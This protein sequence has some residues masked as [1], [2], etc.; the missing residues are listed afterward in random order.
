MSSSH[1]RPLLRTLPAIAVGFAAAGCAIAQQPSPYSLPQR[2]PP[3]LAQAGQSSTSNQQSGQSSAQQSASADGTLPPNARPGE[4]YTRV[5]MAPQYKNVTEQVVKREAGERVVV[6]PARYE[7]APETVVVKPATKRVV[8]N[9][10]VYD[11]VSEQVLVRP[12]SSR[13]ETTPAQYQSVTERVMERA[14]YT[15]WKKGSG[16][17]Q[18]VDSATGEIMCLVE[19]PAVYK[20]ITKQVLKSPAQ[21]REVAI[22]AEYQTVTKQVLKTPESVREIEVPAEYSTVTARKLVSPPTEQRVAIPAEYQTV[23][24]AEQVSE[25]RMEWRQILCETNMTKGKV[26]ELQ[27]ALKS[28]GFDPGKVD[29]V[30]SKKTYGAVAAF[31][32]SKGLPTDEHINAQ[33]VT[34]L[35]VSLR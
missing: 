13:I 24:R 34:A 30:A 20:T 7:D 28:R 25:G 26:T 19:V 22:P 31:Q 2:L 23:T 11:T 6:L 29:G 18:R 16:P 3:L 8:V 12:A 15:T 33:T 14:A 27:R 21:T 32:R 10:A 17:I 5:F 4:C 9:P 1:L 35:G